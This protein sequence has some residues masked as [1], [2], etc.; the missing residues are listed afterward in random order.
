MEIWERTGAEPWDPGTSVMGGK[1]RKEH[2]S[3]SVS[4]RSIEDEFLLR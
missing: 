4:F 1:G 2:S 3:R